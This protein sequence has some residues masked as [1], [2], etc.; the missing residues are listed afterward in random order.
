MTNIVILTN[1]FDATVRVAISSVV[2]G[3]LCLAIG[4]GRND[5]TVR[6]TVKLDGAP[7]EQG[8]ISFFPTPGTT[9]PVAGGQISGGAYT[10]TG[11]K[12]PAIGSHRIEIRSSRKTGKMVPAGSPAPPGSMV[13]E[14]AEAIPAR[15]NSS[16]TLEREMMSGKNSLN[17]DLTSSEPDEPRASNELGT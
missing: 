9:G 8:S 3:C 12:V 5:V 16:S 11:S 17:F 15:Y 2:A 4:C 7:V 14:I 1:R 6:G 10:I 13:E